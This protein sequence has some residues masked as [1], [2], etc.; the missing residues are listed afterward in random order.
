[1]GQFWIGSHTVKLVK[2]FQN[3]RCDKGI[4]VNVVRRELPE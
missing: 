4:G 2:P 1:M 3:D